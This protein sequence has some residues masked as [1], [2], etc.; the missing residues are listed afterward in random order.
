MTARMFAEARDAARGSGTYASEGPGFLSP[1]GSALDRMI[2][3]QMT[4]YP[5][6]WS[7]EDKR[8]MA[9]RDLFGGGLS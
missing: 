8:E 5:A 7:V 4:A 6:A 3:I 1:L 2:A 9:E